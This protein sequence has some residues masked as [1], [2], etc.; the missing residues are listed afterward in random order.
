MA[1][2][3]LNYS[4]TATFFVGSNAQG[5]ALGG[6]LA[7]QSDA[8]PSLPVLGSNFTWQSSVTGQRFVG[9]VVFAGVADYFQTNGLVTA[10]VH[11]NCVD[12][13]QL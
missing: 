8:M 3:S 4:V 7:F 12:S 5:T 10:H 1:S 13:K 2:D 9:K 11:I 6:G